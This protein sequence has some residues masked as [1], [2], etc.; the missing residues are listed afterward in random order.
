M[1][2]NQTDMQD[3]YCGHC[4]DIHPIQ[5][6][7][8]KM[9]AAGHHHHQRGGTAFCR[10]IPFVVFFILA[11]NKVNVVAVT[12]LL[13]LRVGV[14]GHHVPCHYHFMYPRRSYHARLRANEDPRDGR[15]EVW[16]AFATP[17]AAGGI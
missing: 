16:A 15:G 5:S 4:Y 8:K 14:I 1:M 10:A 12:T 6:Q 13:V 7:Y 2:S 11:L 17:R 3:K 9:A